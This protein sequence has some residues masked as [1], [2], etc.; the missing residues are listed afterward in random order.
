MEYG[1]WST[2]RDFQKIGLETLIV[3]RVA[4]RHCFDVIDHNI[5]ITVHESQSIPVVSE[6]LQ[7]R[8]SHSV[9]C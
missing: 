4:S 5:G 9:A 1:V 2:A 3:Y 6:R 7:M 8:N